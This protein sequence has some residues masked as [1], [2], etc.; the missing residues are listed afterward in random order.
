MIHWL[1]PPSPLKEPSYNLPY[2]Q[3][4]QTLYKESE[5]LAMGNY[6]GHMYLI[7]WPNADV[8]VRDSAT[9]C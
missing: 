8:L 1:L 3:E 5:S 2:Q 4:E 7:L 9:T 6:N